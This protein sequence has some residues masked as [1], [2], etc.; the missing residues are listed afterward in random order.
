MSQKSHN[1]LPIIFNISGKPSFY[2]GKAFLKKKINSTSCKPDGPRDKQEWRFHDFH[3]TFRYTVEIWEAIHLW[4]LNLLAVSH[5]RAGAV[6][7]FLPSCFR[8]FGA[9]LSSSNYHASWHLIKVILS[10]VHRLWGLVWLHPVIS[11]IFKQFWK[12]RQ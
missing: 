10:S 6:R 2:G 7:A 11:L 1:R 5:L 4:F 12:L 8:P 3:A 9:V